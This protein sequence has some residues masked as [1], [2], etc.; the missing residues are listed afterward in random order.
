MTITG[1][2]IEYYDIRVYDADGNFM[3]PLQGWEYLE[4]SQRVDRPWSYYI[5]LTFPNVTG[6]EDTRLNFALAIQPDWFILI[7]R[8][9][10]VTLDRTRVFEGVHQTT[11]DQAL[12]DGAAQ[13][14]LY[15]QGYTSWLTRRV[16]VP[17][18]GYDQYQI[19][20]DAE[21]V[22]W[23]F[24]NFTMV[25]PN[26]ADP[27]RVMP[28]L[29][30]GVD[31]FRG[32]TVAYSARYTNLQTV[33]ENLAAEGGLH[34]AIVGQDDPPTSFEWQVREIWGDDRRINS[35][36]GNTPC[37]FNYNAR[38]QDIPILSLN[39]SDE[40]NVVYVGGQGVGNAR[41]ILEL[42]NATATAISPR[43]RKEAF[44]DS[45][46]EGSNDEMLTYGKAY[47][48]DNRAIKEL[49]FNLLQDSNV[50][51]LTDFFLGDIVTVKYHSHLESKEITDI[52]VVCNASGDAS[53][54]EHIDIEMKTLSDTLDTYIE[55]WTT[56]YEDPFPFTA[57]DPGTL[58]ANEN[59]IALFTRN[60]RIFITTNFQ[61][62]PPTW[63]LS[64][65]TLSY[66]TNIEHVLEFVVD[67]YSPGYMGTGTE[68]NGW[69]FTTHAIY[70]ID[71][72]FTAQTVTKQ[73]DL[74]HPDSANTCGA[75][76]SFSEIGYAIAVYGKDSSGTGTHGCYTTDGENWTEN[77]I[78]ATN[79][80]DFNY[81]YSVQISSHLTGYAITSAVSSGVFNAYET[82]DYG[83][84]W[85]LRTVNPFSSSAG[86]PIN[87]HIPWE[88]NS[89]ASVI[90]HSS[91][92]TNKLYR[93]QG[94]A[95]VDVT[96]AANMLPWAGR[97]ALDTSTIDRQYIVGAFKKTDADFYSAYYSSDEGA[98]WDDF[99]GMPTLRH[100][101][102]AS[103]DLN[104][105]FM[106]GGWDTSG[107]DHR[108]IVVRYTN[109]W[110]ATTED[111]TSSIA[112][113]ITNG[114][115]GV[116]ICGGPT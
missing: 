91:H 64:T 19:N 3:G 53:V 113:A 20:T 44:V 69:I 37:F 11:V 61:D 74:A 30:L 17:P 89:D 36:A 63:A 73:H 114:D 40:K 22:M 12:I 90:Y 70:R 103:D 81:E 55:T 115:E 52:N 83:A 86:R 50:R 107:T 109:D 95:T 26:P 100:V 5:R 101:A 23:S 68:I 8:T 6:T 7:Y 56:E 45:R 46:G 66:A 38:S 111:K 21:T 33:I 60:H 29:S 97:W 93:S 16:I 1:I 43:A 65:L 92:A 10:P 34:Y 62:S 105:V 85:I 24:V 48:E 110:F 15:G 112:A 75:D 57:D 28:G 67:A 39:Y 72:I 41:T 59:S 94:A 2:P 9:D 32:N 82:F 96:P 79:R 31:F 84:T 27:D 51:W 25:N 99:Y 76:A 13:V 104:T 108:R 98:S 49:T 78:T 35:S 14:S 102:L 71:D 116:G 88:D 106:W 77:T 42:E 58:P 4:Y 47:L 18:T 80:N 54:I 87:F